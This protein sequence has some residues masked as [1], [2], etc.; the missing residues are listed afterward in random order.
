MRVAAL[1][2]RGERRERARRAPDVAS[3]SR[4][5]PAKPPM[6]RAVDRP[7]RSRRRSRT[8]ASVCVRRFV[9]PLSSALRLDD[10]GALG[11]GLDRVHDSRRPDQAGGEH[12][13][14]P[15][16]GPDVDDGHPGLE[17]SPTSSARWPPTGRSGSTPSPPSRCA[18]GRASCRPTTAS[19]RSAGSAAAPSGPASAR[20]ATST[21]RKRSSATAEAWLLSDWVLDLTAAQTRRLGSPRA[22]VL[23]ALVPGDDD[24]ERVGAELLERPPHLVDLG[25]RTSSGVTTTMP[26]ARALSAI[27]SPTCRNGGAS[28]R[29]RSAWSASS[30]RISADP[31]GGRDFAGARRQVPGGQHVQAAGRSAPS[32][33]S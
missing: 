8:S 28:M 22:V 31:L 15:D 12:R 7:G 14:H 9:R 21:W 23:V 25:R 30:A 11:L 32:R 33:R 18:A 24:A 1:L 13:V 27:A 10:R 5:E 3:P 17:Q 16:V 29:I 19:R 6:V 20:G 4:S 26:S 2:L